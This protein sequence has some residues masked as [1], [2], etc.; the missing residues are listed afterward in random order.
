MLLVLD[1][2]DTYAKTITATDADEEGTLHTKIAYSIVKQQPENMF[3]I[4]RDSGDIYVMHNTLDREVC[5]HSY[6]IYYRICK[7]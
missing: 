7:Q 5:S 4:D 2:S 6:F 1:F 3:Y